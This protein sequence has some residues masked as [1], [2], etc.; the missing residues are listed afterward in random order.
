[1]RIKNFAKIL[2]KKI[3]LFLLIIPGLQAKPIP[4]GS[5][6]GDVPANI[7]ILLDS[8][9]SMRNIVTGGNGTYGV[10]WAVELRDGN[11]IFSELDKG[12]SN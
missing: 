11:I 10:D 2:I 4:P 9:V 5:G 7:L 12:F 6:E 8:S 1:M 3:L